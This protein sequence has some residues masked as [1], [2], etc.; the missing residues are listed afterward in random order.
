M[1]VALVVLTRE[2]RA[3]YRIVL[4]ALPFIVIACAV[5]W[6]SAPH[7]AFSG[8]AFNVWKTIH[9]GVDWAHL[10]Q[11]FDRSIIDVVS[12]EPGLFLHSY[13]I[14]LRDS[15]YAWLPLVAFLIVVRRKPV[16]AI[17]RVVMLAALIY[18]LVTITGGSARGP[19]VILTFSVLAAIWTLLT[20]VPIPIEAKNVRRMALALTAGYSLVGIGFMSLAA[21]TTGD[22][23]ERYDQLA[24]ALQI[25]KAIAPDKI[26][27]DDYALYFPS[28]G[29]ATPRFSGGWPEIGLPSYAKRYPPLPDSTADAFRQALL[30]EGITVVAFR[31]RPLNDVT[32]HIVLKD[33]AH[34][35]SRGSIASYH[36]YDVK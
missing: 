32:F 25:G 22:R 8:T 34:F 30:R 20:L 7:T 26:Y 27:S 10:P 4:G 19:V 1:V 28:V 23:V 35:V 31:G 17:V 12:S 29:G 9:A 5:Q 14:S 18:H 36:V 16:A 15:W 2:W 11:H 33:T 6:W 3:I 21:M 24:N 13:F